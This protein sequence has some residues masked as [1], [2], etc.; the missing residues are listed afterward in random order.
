MGLNELANASYEKRMQRIMRVRRW[1]DNQEAVTVSAVMAKTG[2]ARQTIIKWAKDG[3]IPLF[4][5]NNHTVV[6]L[7][8]HNKPKWWS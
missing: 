1:F 3:D 2:Y 7:T 6:P 4:L 5:D 8:E